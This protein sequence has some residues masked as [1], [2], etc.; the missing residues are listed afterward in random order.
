VLRT[1]ERALCHFCFMCVVVSL[2]PP[3]PPPPRCLHPR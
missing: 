2:P 3:P 1:G